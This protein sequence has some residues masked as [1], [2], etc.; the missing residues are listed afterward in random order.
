MSFG[1]IGENRKQPTRRFKMLIQGSLHRGHP[2]ETVSCLKIMRFRSAQSMLRN[3][4]FL[5]DL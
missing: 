5:R 1:L 2:L 4:H 3:Q